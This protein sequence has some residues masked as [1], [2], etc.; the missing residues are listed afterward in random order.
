MIGKYLYDFN[1][2]R[3]ILYEL[4]KS[5]NPWERRTAIY[6]TAW[7]LKNGELDDT[8]RIAE[9]LLHDEHELVQKGVGT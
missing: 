6:G 7:F 3:D 5:D 1:K 9:I 8:F 2:P 4:A